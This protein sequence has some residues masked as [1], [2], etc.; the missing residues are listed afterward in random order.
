MPSAM[1]CVSVCSGSAEV[2]GFKVSSFTVR[3]II[4]SSVFSVLK[5]I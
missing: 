2:V 1:L 4:I 3:L 5:V